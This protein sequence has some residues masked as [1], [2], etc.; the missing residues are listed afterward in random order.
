[1]RNPP[2]QAFFLDKTHLAHLEERHGFGTMSEPLDLDGLSEEQ[3]QLRILGFGPFS[4][5]GFRPSGFG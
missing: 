4:A 5:F 3:A 2:K 1:V